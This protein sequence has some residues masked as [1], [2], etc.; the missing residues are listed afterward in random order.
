MKHGYTS[1][2]GRVQLQPL[3]GKDAE[4]MRLL[5]N[6]NSSRFFYDHNISPEQQKKW[7]ASYLDTAQDY[8]FSV[9]LQD[10]NHWIGAVGIYNVDL[11][12]M[13]GEFGRL[14]IDKETTVQRGLGVDVT[15]AAC[16]FAFEQLGLK[17]VYLEVYADNIAAIRTYEKSGFEL[18]ETRNAG[19]KKSILYME[20]INNER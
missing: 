19:N 9:Y 16:K 17:M 10:E 20:K 18:Y 13:T 1:R 5:R 2:Y 4:R 6:R 3:T 15:E 7:Y 12:K 14:L 8:M 11:Q